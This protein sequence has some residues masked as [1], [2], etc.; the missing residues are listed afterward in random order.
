MRNAIIWR[1]SS[2]VWARNSDLVEDRG[3]GPE[4]D[5]GAGAAPR[6][7]ADDLELGLDLAALGEVHAVALAVAVDLDLEPL[8]QGV[9]DRHAHAVEAAGDL[10]AAAAEL[11]AGVEHGQRRSRPPTCP[12]RMLVDGDAPAVVDDLAAAV[13]QQ[14]DVDAVAVARH[15]L[16][17]RVVDDLVD[18]VVE[19]AGPGGP[20]VHAGP[21]ADGLE[22]FEDLDVLGAVGGR[23]GHYVVTTGLSARR[24]RCTRRR[25]RRAGEHCCQ[26]RCH[27]WP[28][29]LDDGAD[30]GWNLRITMTSS[31]QQGVTVRPIRGA[32][33]GGRMRTVE[34][35]RWP[36]CEI[37]FRVVH[38]PR[39]PRVGT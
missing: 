37:R 21:L 17:D 10:V 1:R 7:L 5:G 31:Y 2:R 6:G 9:D 27:R 8:G 39:K 13:G 26:G 3:V 4:A 29:R 30:R 25:P 33:F 28:N 22:A 19:A 20:D 16:V 36:P 38:D 18:E 11:A 15:G 32:V 12:W 14:G 35:R 34:G 23:V 24:S